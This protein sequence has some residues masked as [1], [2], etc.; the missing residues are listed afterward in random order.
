MNVSICGSCAPVPDRRQQLLRAVA[1][2]AA[3]PWLAAQ[4]RPAGDMAAAFAA[5]GFDATLLALG[6]V[7]ASSEQITLELPEHV[8]DG[9]LVPVSVTSRLPGSREIFIVVDTNPQ[10]LAV[11]FAVPEGTLPF[12]ATRIRMAGSGTVCAAVRTDQGLYAVA[13][14]AEV[15]VG[16]CG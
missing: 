6:G 9:A 15:A 12:V 5:R 16:G 4:A 13:R 14:R 11:R 8:A 10:P 1:L 7:P 3:G 2:V